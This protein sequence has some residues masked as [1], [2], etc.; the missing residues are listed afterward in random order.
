MF[1]EVF[2]T[3]FAL[4]MLKGMTL[5][6]SYIHNNTFPNPLSKGDELHYFELLKRGRTNSDKDGIDNLTIVQT[7]NLLIEHNL[8]LVA[9][10]VKQFGDTEEKNEDLLSIG[11][12]GLIKAVDTFK[13]ELKGKF[14]SYAIP[15]IKNEILMQYRKDR[16]KLETSLYKPLGQDDCEDELTMIDRLTAVNKEISDQIIEEEN[17]RLLLENV[18]KLPSLYRQV[19]I[20]RYGLRNSPKRSQQQIANILQISRSYVSR[21]EKNARQLLRRKL[22]EI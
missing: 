17:Q 10:V 9:F 15:C 22:K 11:I 16:G 18:E 3:S 4:S 14:S 1:A 6:V 8:R 7:R 2:L 5:L 20:M 19:L 21:I 12:I 13:P